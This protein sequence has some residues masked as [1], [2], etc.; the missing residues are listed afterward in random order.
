M[1]I[2]IKKKEISKLRFDFKKMSFLDP[3]I[4]QKLSV[5]RF[6]FGW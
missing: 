1:F 4:Y 5:V 2:K 3:D 6:N